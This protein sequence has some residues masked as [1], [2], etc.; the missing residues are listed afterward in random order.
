MVYFFEAL[1]PL[2]FRGVFFALLYLNKL[3]LD[4]PLA[5]KFTESVVDVSSKMAFR[6]GIQ[7]ADFN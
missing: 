5:Y 3:L 7:F 2:K 4:L 6:R 1:S